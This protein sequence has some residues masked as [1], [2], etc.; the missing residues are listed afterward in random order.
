M[1]GSEY[2]VIIM[3][4]GVTESILSGLLSMEGRKVLHVDRNPFYGD[5]GASLNI[6]SLWNKFR[7]GEP[8]PQELGANREWNIDLIPKFVMAYGKL[9]KLI[10][11]TKV[12]DYLS[13]KCV[14]GTYVYQF[15]KGGFFSKGGPKIEKVPANDKEALSSNLMSLF[16]KRRCQKFFQYVQKYDAKKPETFVKNDP[17]KK[18]F[19][20]FMQYFELEDNTI[21]F[22]GHA[23]A[24]YETD[25]FINRPAIEVVE[26]IQLYMDSVGR[27]GDSP[28]IYPVYGLAGIPESFARKCAVYGGTF[29]LNVGL[30][31][32]EYDKKSGLT[33]F[34]GVFENEEG[35]AKAKMIIANPAYFQEMKHGELLR[36]IGKAIR[37]ICI[38]DHPIPKTGNSNAVQIIL[39]QKQTGRKS[40][41]Y[42]MMIGSSH[43]VCKKGYYLAIISSTSES[44]NVEKDLEVAFATIG[45]IRYK[46][47][48]EEIMYKPISDKAENSWHITNTLD[49]TSHFESAADNVMSIY[50]AITGR[51]IDLNIESTQE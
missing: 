50:K 17:Q 32:L 49:P 10:I 6:T 40:D 23:I 8:V 37:V 16:E 24:L 27:F 39:P 36:S 21:D 15:D 26:K 44:P 42:I 35:F 48:T 5:S 46:F 2:D 9:V 28:F 14:D 22:I 47:I 41:I 33:T 38:L 31:S 45:P 13:W 43:G 4:T 18:K 34:K 25:E 29:M 30:R 11:K 19:G 51:D 20:D 12:S 3:G 1:D 7:P